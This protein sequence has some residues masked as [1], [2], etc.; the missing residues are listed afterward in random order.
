MSFLPFAAGAF[1]LEFG[2]G[3]GEVLLAH[4]LALEEEGA[5]VHALGPLA[6]E[7]LV[8]DVARQH[9]AGDQELSETAGGDPHASEHGRGDGTGAGCAR[10]AR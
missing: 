5:Q 2:D 1:A 4:V 3:G 7:E 6:G 10:S 9:P 8:E